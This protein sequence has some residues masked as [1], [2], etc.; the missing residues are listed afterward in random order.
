MANLDYEQEDKARPL[1]PG[2]FARI[3]IST[4]GTTDYPGV[5]LLG[6]KGDGS[7]EPIKSDDNGR[8]VVSLG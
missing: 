3:V 2:G 4:L 6:K 7:Y 8:L 1:S 5:V